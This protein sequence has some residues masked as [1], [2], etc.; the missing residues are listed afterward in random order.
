M[1]KISL[2]RNS[3]GY[4]GTDGTTA[5]TWEKIA[6]WKAPSL[7]AYAITPG[8]VIKVDIEDATPAQITTG[9]MKIEI[10]SP[11][12]NTH[13]LCGFDLS[14][15]DTWANQKDKLK[16]NVWPSEGFVPP[17]YKLIIKYKSPT[18][19]K[20][21]NCKYALQVDE[22][23]GITDAEVKENFPDWVF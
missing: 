17:N 10:E 21:A 5:D 19:S 12:G 4:T 3:D 8:D 2:T 7:T 16:Q 9:Q 23:I 6:E 15:W 1:V 11:S 14:E 18:A 22:I 13:K 20:D